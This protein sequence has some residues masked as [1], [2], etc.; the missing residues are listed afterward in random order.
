MLHSALGAQQRLPQSS[1]SRRSEDSGDCQIGLQ[2]YSASVTSL[3]KMFFQI[4]MGALGVQYLSCLRLVIG[5]SVQ[6][7][8]SMLLEQSLTGR[9]WHCSSGKHWT[10]DCLK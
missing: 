1:C 4:P 2:R 9:T 10:G 5:R 8:R 6:A 7:V 3:T